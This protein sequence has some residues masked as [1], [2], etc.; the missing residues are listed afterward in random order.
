MSSVLTEMNLLC[1]WEIL[2]SWGV[3]LDENSGRALASVC[4]LTAM[5]LGGLES[6]GV[7]KGDQ[8][9]TYRKSCFSKEEPARPPLGSEWAGYSSGTF[10]H[11]C[12]HRPGLESQQGEDK[13]PWLA[14]V[15][16]EC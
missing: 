4:S 7:G 9:P 14:Q 12:G 2:G 3:D 10:A 1:L 5:R 13:S 6:R 11:Y 15:P 8:E 16:V